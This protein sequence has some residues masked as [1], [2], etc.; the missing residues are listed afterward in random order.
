M[1]SSSY[2]FTPKRMFHIG[3]TA[4]KSVNSFS[5]VV[6]AE[7]ADILEEAPHLLARDILPATL[8]GFIETQERGAIT[9]LAAYARM[10][11]PQMLHHYGHHV[12]AKQVFEGGRDCLMGPLSYFLGL[13]GIYGGNT[14]PKGSLYGQMRSIHRTIG[15]SSVR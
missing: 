1:N 8:P 6:A 2:P 12:E 10:A 13:Q 11:V 5:C 7:L 3:F 14:L 15:L 4:I 9:A